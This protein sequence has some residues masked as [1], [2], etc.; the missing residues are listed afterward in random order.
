MNSWTWLEH[1]TDN[2][3][4]GEKEIEKETSCIFSS[5]T[6][7]NLEALVLLSFQ[8]FRKVLSS[9]CSNVRRFFRSHRQNNLP[10][11]LKS[12]SLLLQARYFLALL[13]SLKR[14]G[15]KKKRSDARLFISNFLNLLFFFLRPKYPFLLPV[16]KSEQ[17]I[18]KTKM[19]LPE[20]LPRYFEV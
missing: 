7:Q 6:Y 8:W 18:N 5:Q 3:L 10:A 4:K 12:N 16:F 17:A 2:S 9:L 20:C 15:N 13:L 14:M 11:S 19:V 1:N